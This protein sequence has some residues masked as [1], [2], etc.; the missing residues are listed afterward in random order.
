LGRC[1]NISILEHDG[2]FPEIS[3]PFVQFFDV[4]TTVSPGTEATQVKAQ[5]INVNIE[6]MVI[7][8]SRDGG[9]AEHAQDETR[10]LRA[11]LIGWGTS[12]SRLRAQFHPGR[13]QRLRAA[14]RGSDCSRSIK[15][16]EMSVVTAELPNSGR[17][18][19]CALLGGA[20]VIR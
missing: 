20:A 14:F 19:C 16:I 3:R 18:G 4:T 9:D 7:R 6:I 10:I 11:Q 2:G 5:K 17:H 13:R 8:T 1:E 12:K 15:L